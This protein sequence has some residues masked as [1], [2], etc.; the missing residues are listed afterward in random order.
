[1]EPHKQK[2]LRCAIYTR[3]SSEEGIEQD[4]NSLDAQR[5]ACEAFIEASE[6]KVGF[7]TRAA[8]MT[9]ACRVPRWSA[10]LSNDCSRTSKKAWWTSWWF[11][12]LIG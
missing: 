5:E 7:Y 4:F 9:A 3:K 12:K 6:E 2:E 11:T 10:R 8:T 1:V